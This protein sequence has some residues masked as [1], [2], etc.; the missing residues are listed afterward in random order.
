MKKSRGSMLQR[1]TFAMNELRVGAMA[2]RV[3]IFSKESELCGC[4]AKTWVSEVVD[5]NL[6]I[7][8]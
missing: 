5:R 3:D 4:R 6:S 7:T 2:R 1:L 8:W